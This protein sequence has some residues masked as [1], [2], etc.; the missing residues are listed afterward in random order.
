MHVKCDDDAENIVCVIMHIQATPQFP[1][2]S[3][4]TLLSTFYISFASDAWSELIF[5]PIVEN[6]NV[7][8]IIHVA[9]E[10]MHICK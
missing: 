1:R 10:F 6:W 9:L 4:A 5:V 2:V 3:F 8:I 7:F